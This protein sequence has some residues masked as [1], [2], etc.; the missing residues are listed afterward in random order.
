MKKSLLYLFALGIAGVSADAFAQRTQVG[1]MEQRQLPFSVTENPASDNGSAVW[2][3]K[4]VMTPLRDLTED[5]LYEDDFS[6]FSL[7]ISETNG[8]GEFELVTE[9]PELMIQYMGGEPVAT[10][11]ADNGFAIFNGIQYLI[12]V[13]VNPQ[14]ATLTYDGSFDFSEEDNVAFAFDQR[15][16]AFNAN[17]VSFELSV[18]QGETWTSYIMNPDLAGNA[19]AVQNR[20]VTNV[21]DVVANQPDVRVRFR[22]FNA[23]DSNTAGSGYGWAVDDMAFIIPPENYIT[24]VEA[25][26]DEW[27]TINDPAIFNGLFGQ[28]IDM[29]D[30][31]EYSVYSADAVRPLTFTG[32]VKNLGTAAQTNVTFTV[33]LTDPDGTPYDYSETLETLPAGETAIMQIVDVMPPPFNLGDAEMAA[34]GTYT[35]SFA[36]DQ[37]EEDFLPGDNVVADKTFRV[38]E[39]YLGH[40]RPVGFTYFTALAGAGYEAFSRYSYQEQAEVDYIEFALT[41]GPVNPEDV[42]FES[43]QLDIFTGSVYAAQDAPNDVIESFFFDEE[44]T[45]SLSYFITDAEIF[46]TTPSPA[47]ETNWVRVMLP[48]PITVNPGFI[49]NASIVVGS[50]PDIGAE[51]FIWPLAQGNNPVTSSHFF[52]PFQGDPEVS[53]FIGRTAFAIRMGNSV[54]TINTLDNDPVTFRLGQNYPNPVNG[55]ETLIDWELLEPAQNVVFTVHDM[56]GRLVEQRKMGDRPAGIQETIRLNTN[57]AAGVYQYALVVGNYRAVRKMVVTK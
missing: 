41:T 37:D 21:S 12:A 3:E 56:N 44:G 38:D 5:I 17:Q 55:T 45:S 24:L 51:D 9:T 33:T 11:T 15:Y 43:I 47:D 40:N 32:E 26:Y 52:G 25:W 22:W 57:L 10:T 18:D 23:S 53:L 30:S 49:Y 29:V 8:Q 28:D 39:E 27:S 35:V 54:S 1:E 13:D 14:D 34:L 19:P 50:A 46:N 4:P 7:W 31:Y 42:L 36:V 2:A 48:E 6:D 20:L 16:R